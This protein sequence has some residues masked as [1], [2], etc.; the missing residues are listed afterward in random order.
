MLLIVAMQILQIGRC[1]FR[2]VNRGTWT[3]LYRNMVSH[4]PQRL[5]TVSVMV[6]SISVANCVD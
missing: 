5:I 2:K 6:V 4:P 1:F 3:G